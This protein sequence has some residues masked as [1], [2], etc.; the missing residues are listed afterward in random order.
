MLI[1]K[2]LFLIVLFL[3]LSAWHLAQS[4]I[5]D[6]WETA[7]FN[8]D[9]WRYFVG[10]SEPDANWRSLSF[11]DASW[12]QGPGGFGYSDNDDNTIIPQCTAVYLRIK[13]N[14][15]DTALIAKALLSMDYDDA[16]VAYLNNV[17]IARAGITG[18]YPT[19]NQTGSDH[20]ATMYA[21]GEPVSFI[22]DKRLLKTCLLPGENI[23]AVQVHNSSLTSSDLSSNVFLSFGIFNSAFL[24]RPVPY[25]F[26]PPLDF[27]SSNLPIVI[28]NT[29]GGV[30]IQDD[31]RV[32]A[33]M[34]IIYRGAGLRNYPDDQNIPGY[35]NYDGRIS[36]E[37]RGSSSQA[38]PKKQ[39]GFTTIKADG[40]TNNNVSLL[41]LPAENDWILN[42]LVFD[43][44]LMRNYLCFNLSRQIGEYASR[45]VYCE[46]MLNGSYMGLYLLLEKIKPDAAR[47]DIS[48]IAKEDITLPDISG[49]YIIKADK[50]TGGDPIAWTMSSYLGTND[51]GFIHEWPDPENVNIAQTGYIKSEFDK[52]S[53]SASGSDN[54]PISG[55]PAV[56]DMPSFINYM[57]INEI[58]AN[59]DA[60]QFSTFYHKDR[61]GKL[62]AG[63]I[64]D[65]DLTYGND[66][67]FWGFNRSL[68]DKWQFNNGDN[69]GPKF[70]KDLYNNSKF[71]CYLSKRWNDLIQPGQALNYSSLESYIDKT[72]L[73]IR[74]AAI[75]ENVK[76]GTSANHDLEISKMKSWLQQRIT[77]MTNTLGSYSDCASVDIPPLVI[78]KIMYAPDSTVSFPDSKDQEFLE[79]VNTGSKP[80]DLTGVYFSRTGFVYQFPANSSIE[81]GSR[82]ILAA[83]K[84]IFF[85]K[86]GI[87]PSGQFT[88]NLSNTGETLVLANAYGDIIDSVS[89]SDQPPW[90]D[91]RGNGY[92]L[93]LPDP[94]SD[95]SKGSNWIAANAKIV[96]VEDIE[97]D[98]LLK[99]YPSPVEEKLVLEY[100]GGKYILQLY[101]FQGNLLKTLSVNSELYNL[102]MTQYKSGIYLIRVLTSGRNFVRKIIKE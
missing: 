2:K 39:Y 91:A 35:L 13:F 10:I 6:H 44:S 8:N 59:A 62:R 96:G 60:Y 90:P 102:D 74:E 76:W 65:L 17:E 97:S 52:L 42:G 5:I 99:L 85:A 22:F 70:W 66:L 80:V 51:V 75:R 31:P 101:D 19:F 36:I 1:M 50:T 100:A 98:L 15:P 77:W 12:A 37:I 32:M 81:V 79:I 24:F 57:I 4:Q 88:R 73:W 29:D 3:L 11:N 93:E 58:S 9:T 53:F 54:S 34:K 78:S 83:N 72:A 47:V 64:W 55:Y 25:W 68:T 86:Y 63:P 67:F 26:K 45:T 23:L 41:G 56:I 30:E 94:L 43:Q 61:N 38:T 33:N 7:I 14:M 82:K 95:N 18:T 46:L 84:T 27:S 49:G 16:F 40:I 87:V 48:K 92:Y 71:R 69:E 89:Y 28:I 20:E 21:G